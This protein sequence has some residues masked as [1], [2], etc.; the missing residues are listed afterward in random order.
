MLNLNRVSRLELQHE[1]YKPNQKTTAR[2][3]LIKQYG[4][5]NILNIAFILCWMKFND[6]LD[7]SAALFA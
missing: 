4:L 2:H 3:D 6:E 5:H 1:T 7:V